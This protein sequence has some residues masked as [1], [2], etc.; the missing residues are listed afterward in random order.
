MTQKIFLQ[1][2]DVGYRTLINTVFPAVALN[3]FSS[4]KLKTS[5]WAADAKRRTIKAEI[6]MI[7]AFVKG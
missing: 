3:Q 2:Q 1:E 4:V 6:L 5:P 7:M